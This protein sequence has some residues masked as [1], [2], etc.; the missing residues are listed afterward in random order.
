MKTSERKE[1]LKAILEGDKRTVDRLTK[2]KPIVIEFTDFA[3]QREALKG[4]G[5]SDAEI[6]EYM[7]KQPS[8]EAQLNEINNLLKKLENE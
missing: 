2:V 6:D 5:C 3:K 8:H 4:F 1:L 7:Q